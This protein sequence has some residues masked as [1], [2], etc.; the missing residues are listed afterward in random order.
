VHIIN[1][2]YD[3]VNHR[4]CRRRG[5]DSDEEGPQLSGGDRGGDGG[6]GGGGGDGLTKSG[7]ALQK[8]L[9]KT[10][11]DEDGSDAEHSSDLSPSPGGSPVPKA[12]ENDWWGCCECRLL[13]ELPRKT[14]LAEGL[15]PSPS[16][17]SS[18]VPKDRRA[19]FLQVQFLESCSPGGWRET[20]RRV[21]A[22]HS[23]ARRHLLC[24]VSDASLTIVDAILSRRIR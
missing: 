18:P 10:G 14:G 20:G 12:G 11:L 19:V 2:E 24:C 13:K 5:G 3:L 21:P 22:A 23:A 4:F 9:R 6:G 1:N 16:P 15:G 8:L 17:R 7:K